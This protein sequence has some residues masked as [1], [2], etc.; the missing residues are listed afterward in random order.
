[1]PEYGL[2]IQDRTLLKRAIDQ[3]DPIAQKYIYVKYKHFIFQFIKTRGDF[4]EYI[5]DL[6]QEVFV[7]IY[8]G[9]CKYSGNSEVR[10]YLCGIA[11][12]LVKYHIRREQRRVRANLN[13]KNNVSVKPNHP[14]NIIIK[15][16]NYQF[17]KFH[18]A[19]RQAIATLPPKSREAVELAL[20]HKIKPYQA[21]KKL[22]CSSV[23]FRNRLHHGLKKLRK[24]HSKFSNFFQS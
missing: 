24:E 15:S 3:K 11:K 18:R 17:V 10:G 13:Y 23:I 16:D 7:N 14:A 4:G 5:D 2:E 19:L 9:K 6:V 20:I 8:D 21:A 22:G 12:N 1:M